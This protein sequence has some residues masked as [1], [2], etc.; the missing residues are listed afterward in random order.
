MK[1]KKKI[2]KKGRKQAV[3]LVRFTSWTFYHGGSHHGSNSF[4]NFFSFLLTK[5]EREFSLL[6][7]LFIYFCMPKHVLVSQADTWP[8]YSREF[9]SRK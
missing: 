5:K 7:L 1:L 6:F 4:M 9:L 3:T 2:K 8:A